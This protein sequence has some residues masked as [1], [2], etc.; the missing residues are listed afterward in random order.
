MRKS[1][2]I[3]ADIRAKQA[4]VKNMT[5]SAEIEAAT[6]ELQAL[7]RE[8]ALAV[9]DENVARLA[10]AR[11][12]VDP[13][14]PEAKEAKR[15]SISK[16][17]REGMAG[18]EALTGLEKEMSEEGLRE[19]SRAGKVS[20]RNLVI[21]S[22]VL[23]SIDVN[24]VA[25]ATEGKEFAQVTRMSYLEALQ[26]ALVCQKLGAVYMDGLQ[27]NVRIVKGGTATAGWYS[28]ADAA[29][30]QK[31][32]FSAVNMTPKRLQVLAGYTMD[33]LKQTSL[34]VDKI[35]LNE[36]IRAHA[37]GLDAAAFT[38]TGSN[39]Q[40]TGIL[41]TTGIGA[42]VMG[43]N[44]GALTR[45]KLIDLETEVAQDNAL[46][47]ALAYVTNSK[48]AG[49]MK[50]TESVTG[51]PDWL[52]EDGKANGYPVAITNAIP[53]NLTKGTA[54]QV[55]SAMIF[56]NFNELLIGQWGGL[57]VIID[58]FASK[59]KAIIEVTLF[60]YH[61]ILVRRPEAFAAVQ[62]LLTA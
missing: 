49:K 24:N 22:I 47:G 9:N 48:V 55:C 20:E 53:S 34:S 11:S 60:A 26:N 32:S 43:T 23:R 18:A 33:L 1:F 5:E 19:M 35:I 56:G 39:G 38:G 28:E 14:S 50:K 59:A 15:F 6:K 58:P 17:L 10:A 2:E 54:S 7:E 13:N 4:A 42:V 31:I 45:D 62:D 37:A 12:V 29:S 16:F 8:L 21:P 57:D 30:M 52:L 51:Y 25:T 27:G 44:G 46:F 36:L 3:L 41:N 40:P 61:D